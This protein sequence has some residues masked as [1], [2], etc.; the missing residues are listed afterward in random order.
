VLEYGE[1]WIGTYK[2]NHVLYFITGMYSMHVNYAIHLI[3]KYSLTLRQCFDALM[4]IVRLEKHHFF[5]EKVL[6]SVISGVK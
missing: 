4:E 2:Q 5:D 1:K 3:E 6:E